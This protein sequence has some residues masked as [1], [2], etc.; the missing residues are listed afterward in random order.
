LISE[1]R[2]QSY[3]GYQIRYEE[4][5]KD[6]AKGYCFPTAIVIR[7]LRLLWLQLLVQVPPEV[8]V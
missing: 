8:A 2:V 7:F 1:S 3:L 6:I 5:V 4:Q